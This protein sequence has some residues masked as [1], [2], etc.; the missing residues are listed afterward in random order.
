VSLAYIPRWYL[1][2]IGG[3]DL[4]RLAPNGI[5]LVSS[6]YEFRGDYASTEYYESGGDGGN[7]WN[8]YNG[9]T[10]SVWQFT[11]AAIVAG[12]SVDCN[13]Y[14]GDNLDAL[15]TGNVF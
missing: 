6:A 8:S 2:Q 12:L 9:G 1:G 10:P 4:S 11:D 3:G 14:K 5:S 13:A 15:F 7:G